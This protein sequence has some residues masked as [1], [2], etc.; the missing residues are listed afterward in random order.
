MHIQTE[1]QP[2]LI[3]KETTFDAKAIDI[4]QKLDVQQ[5]YC[6]DVNTKNGASNRTEISLT[7]VKQQ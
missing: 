4:L 2:Y 6:S 5:R 7:L 3:H 1:Q